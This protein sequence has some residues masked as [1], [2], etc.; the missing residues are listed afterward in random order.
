MSLVPI[1]EVFKRPSGGFVKTLQRILKGLLKVLLAATATAATAT[2]T[3]EALLA[4]LLPSS[5]GSHRCWMDSTLGLSWR[6]LGRGSRV[7][8]SK[9]KRCIGLTRSAGNS[10]VEGR[11]DQGRGKELRGFHLALLPFSGPPDLPFAL[12]WAPCQSMTP[13]HVRIVKVP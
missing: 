2:A 10:Q 12:P 7:A 8:D 9:I 3:T 4:A 11:E 1:L 5:C 13:P 6:R